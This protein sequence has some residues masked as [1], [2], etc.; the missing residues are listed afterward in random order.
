MTSLVNEIMRFFAPAPG[1]SLL[2]QL[3]YHLRQ[4]G[5]EGYAVGGFVR[6]GLLGRATRDI[7]VAID[8]DALAIASEVAESFGAKMVPLDEPNK[9]A[10]VVL[11]HEGGRQHLDFSTL[12]GG[13][14]E[15][16]QLRDF[17]IDAIA[18]DLAEIDEGWSEVTIIDPTGGMRDLDRGVVRAVREDVFQ[19][20]PARLLRAV[21]LAATLDFS[22]DA[23]TEALVQ[24]DRHLVTSVAAERLRDELCLTLETPRAYPALRRLDRLGLLDVLIPELSTA[25]GVTQP[26]EHYWDV[27][28]HSLETVAEVENVLDVPDTIGEDD[29]LALVPWSAEIARHFDEEISGGHSRRALLK[30]AALLHDIAKPAARTVEAD[31]R[32]RFLGHAQQGAAVAVR[33]LERLRFSKRETRLVELM[34]EHHLRPGYLTREETPSRRAV[35]KYF[36][37]TADVGIDTLYLG[38]AD[39]LAARGPTLDPEQWRQHTETTRHLLSKW[40]EEREVVAPPKLIDGHVLMEKLGLAPGPRIGEVL[41]MVREAHAAGDIE[42][43]DEALDFAAKQLGMNQ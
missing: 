25:R 21:R 8:G 42:T 34:V 38:L 10:R 18:I 7:D 11:T 12:R 9:I 40:F 35:Y 29:A 33:V 15:D 22:V 24:R 3:H 32:M 5:I 6:D 19:A 16:L 39:H 28:D 27:F 41:E 14:E 1:A 23:V 37:D 13:I 31:G 17:T 20:D 43:A 4:R 2:H 36:R 26:K 30:L